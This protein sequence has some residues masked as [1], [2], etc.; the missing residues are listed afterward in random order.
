MTTGE[1]ILIGI[2]LVG[3]GVDGILLWRAVRRLERAIAAVSRRGGEAGA[4]IDIK[5][6]IKQIADDAAFRRA[7][8]PSLRRHP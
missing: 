3:C 2:A 5:E 6:S 4:R 1:Y 7:F 8:G